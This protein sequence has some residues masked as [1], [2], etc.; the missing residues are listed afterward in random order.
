MPSIANVLPFCK[1]SSCRRAIRSM[2]ASTFPSTVRS[3]ITALPCSGSLTHSPSIFSAPTDSPCKVPAISKKPPFIAAS[4]L[5]RRASDTNDSVPI[6][7][8]SARDG[9]TS[10]ASGDTARMFVS[11]PLSCI[12]RCT[13]P[14]ATDFVT[15]VRSGSA[16]E[17]K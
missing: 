7:A 9:R 5:Y 15:S 1:T 10:T 6:P 11:T 14:R 4:A 2:Y 16:K 12:C 13:I 8:L 17:R 3:P